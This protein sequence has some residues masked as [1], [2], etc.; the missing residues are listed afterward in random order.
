MF[1]GCLIFK[2]KEKYG[3]PTNGKNI[4]GEEFYPEIGL[5]ERRQE[6]QESLNIKKEILLYTCL[7]FQN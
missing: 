1:S 6:K 5:Q 7:Y 4:G 3:C 2:K